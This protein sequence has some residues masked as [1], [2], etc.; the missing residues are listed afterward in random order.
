MI[1][2]IIAGSILALGLGLMAENAQAAQTFICDD[3]R[4]LKVELHRLEHMKQTESCVATHYGLVVQSV[5]LPVQRPV[6]PVRPVLKGSQTTAKTPPEIGTM[7]QATTSF[8]KVRIINARR[9]ARGWY[10][11]TR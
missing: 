5:P 7:A 3:G 8:R 2:R 1:L 6:R 10:F 11:H 4:L 9:G